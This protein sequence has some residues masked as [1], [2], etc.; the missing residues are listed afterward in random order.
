MLALP[1]LAAGAGFMVSMLALIGIWAVMLCTS[2]LTLEVTLAF[3]DHNN[4]FGT[5]AKR[6][7]GLP[8]SIASWIAYLLLLYATT[9]AYI[10]GSTSLLNLL[11]KNGLGIV[12]PGWVNALS[13]TLVFGFFVFFSMRAVDYLIRGL[14]S[15]KGILIIVTILLLMPYVDF[16]KLLSSDS[17]SRYIWAA[18]PIFLNAFGFHFVIPSVTSY[19]N[20]DAKALRK[21]II[22]ASLIPLVIYILWLMVTLGIIPLSGSHSFER[23]ADTGGSVGGFIDSLGYLV[24]DKTV[25]GF[26]NAFSNIAMTTSF[27]GVSLGLF[28]FLADGCKRDD[29]H[30]GRLQTALLTFIPP[31]G[32]AILYPNGFILALEYSTIFAV[33]LEIF[34]PALMAYKLVRIKELHSEYHCVFNRPLMTGLL[35]LFGVVMIGLVAMDRLHLLPYVF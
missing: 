28:D 6:T 29:S 12:L 1:I 2:L 10:S 21:I 16:T 20:K 7:L 22:I 15:V 35:L 13:F 19:C 8:G 34:L 31:L 26:I 24:H 11:L 17:Q 3:E 5:M 32:F 30:K 4:S 9:A 14:L 27:L 23:I 18:L 33:I 25:N